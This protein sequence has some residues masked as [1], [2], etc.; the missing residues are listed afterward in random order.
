MTLYDP[1]K[2]GMEFIPAVG[3]GV[4][5]GVP[6][7]AGYPIAGI[8]IHCLQ[9]DFS[10][11]IDR[12]CDA[13]K[14]NGGKPAH[15]SLHYVVGSQGQVIQSVDDNNIAWAFSQYMGNFPAPYPLS[16]ISWPP[17]STTYPGITPDYYTLNIG[18]ETGFPAP[19]TTCPTCRGPFNLL[20]EAYATLV[21][22][23]AY[24]SFTYNLPLD[25]T[26]ITAD[27][28]INL[29]AEDECPCLDLTQLYQDVAAYC[30]PCER[31]AIYRPEGTPAYLIGRTLQNCPDNPNCLG[32]QGDDGCE[33]EMPMAGLACLIRPPAGVAVQWAGLDANQC[34]VA[35]TLHTVCPITGD[36]TAANP[37]GLDLCCITGLITDAPL[38]AFVGVGQDGCLHQG[39][40][41]VDGCGIQGAGTL[42]SPLTFDLCCAVREQVD[43]GTAVSWLGVDATGCP[44]SDVLHTLCGIIG[45]GTVADPLA[46]DLCCIAQSLALRPTEGFITIDANGCMARGIVH[47]VGP[48]I[49]N[50]T[51]GSP[52]ALDLCL[53]GQAVPSINPAA[54]WLGLDAAGCLTHDLIHTAGIV[55]GDGTAANPIR[56]TLNVVNTPCIY[57]TLQPDGTLFSTLAISPPISGVDNAL[58]CAP[59]GAYVPQGANVAVCGPLVGEGTDL[60]CLDIDFALLDNEDLC[61]LGTVIPSGIVQNMVGTNAGC[62][63]QE[64]ACTVVVRCETPFTGIEGPG[65]DIN[66]GGINGHAPTIAVRLSADAG[67]LA[68]FGSDGGLLV[69]YDLCA[70]LAARPFGGQ[71]VTGVNGTLLVGA[72][73]RHYVLPD[74]PAFPSFCTLLSTA[75][76]P[77]GANLPNGGLVLSNDCLWHPL[78]VCTLLT[79][80]PVNVTAIPTDGSV[81][82]LT[83]DCEFR[84]LTFVVPPVDIC[85]LLAARP[86]GADIVNGSL[87]LGN[88]C[89][90]HA[91]N[92]CTLLTALPSVPGVIP[93]D[94]SIRVLGND[95]QYH[96]INVCTLIGGQVPVNA[97]PMASGTYVLSQGCEFRPLDICTMLAAV[98]G[99]ISVFNSAT[100][101]VLGSDC[102]FHPVNAMP[103]ARGCGLAGTGAAATP[104]TTAHP[105]WPYACPP[106]SGSATACAPDGTIRGM[107]EHT[108]ITGYIGF[109]AVIVDAK[110]LPVRAFNTF[111]IDQNQSVTITNP[112]PCRSM[113]LHVI[114]GSGNK[115]FSTNTA[116]LWSVQYQ[117]TF[118]LPGGSPASIAAASNL[119]TNNNRAGSPGVEEIDIYHHSS[120]IILPPGGSVTAQMLRSYSVPTGNNV[121]AATTTTTYYSFADV[122][123]FGSTI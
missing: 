100:M 49:G 24:L 107:P 64:D 72:D 119:Y 53:L 108:S 117:T 31:P 25:A 80:V 58:S 110:T 94:A 79:S 15:T 55:I 37:L 97:A 93:A 7:R 34:L 59:S 38:T 114:F 77:T 6:G 19:G 45:Y 9:E 66:P 113:A 99:G 121:P 46:L 105:A 122:W 52:I 56:S 69:T 109:P 28:L 82:V 61:D 30:E 54:R 112:S 102:Q 73:C 81:M 4:P 96:P 95:C 106:A 111:P 44:V 20:P 90:Y 29:M 22:L 50:G 51:V 86:T 1:T 116:A 42:L 35:D 83:D 89:S 67:Q 91:L 14:Y 65:I 120:V 98:P 78:N 57:M 47:V 74:A 5:K 104:L 21:K 62:L 87:L 13:V 101:M 118:N 48:L 26:H 32:N 70:N 75:A 60:S 39:V 36:G 8:V 11:Y 63:I 2:P 76:L 85:T 103:V 40:I 12:M 115:I 10:Q 23:L 3:F 88:D 41:A 43:A 123:W 33:V 16:N 27:Q 71:A 18:I 17:L 84:P 92:V 68:S